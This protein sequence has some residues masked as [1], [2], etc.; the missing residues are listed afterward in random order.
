MTTTCGFVGLSE[1]NLGEAEWRAVREALERPTEIAYGARVTEFERTVAGLLGRRC[2]VAVSSGTAALHLALLAA[3]VGRGEEVLMPTLTFVAPA[4]AVRYVDAHPVLF[5]AEPEY[6][7]LDV[8]RLA[9]WV[10]ENCRAAD[11]EVRNLRSGRRVAAL[12]AVDLLGHPCDLDGLGEIAARLGLPLIDDAAESL[13]ATL[14]ARPAGAAADF[15][16]L[17]F[18]V[19]KV[20]TS[21]GGGMVLCDSEDLARHIRH[22]A[23]QAKVEGPGYMHDAIGFNYRMASV[24]AA[25][26][27]V[28]VGRL[29][30]FLGAKRSIAAHY[31]R[32]LTGVPGVRLTREAPWA[33]ST[34]WL[35]GIEIESRDFGMSAAELAERLTLR[36]IVSRPIFTP[37]HQ[38]GV[39]A[40]CQAQPCPVAE[41][42]GEQCL[43]LPSSTSIGMTELKRVTDAIRE[44]AG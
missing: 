38:R 21:G 19:N 8:E 27:T 29:D 11:G 1:P 10:K 32:E 35:Y 20:V 6:R 14:R 42:L 31:A 30:E 5:D 40:D 3:K 37:L 36:R 4:N 24:Q 34:H 2:A 39:H 33:S 44:F 16:C 28:Q 26:G 15:V 17:S 23:T 22:L 43:L 25:L 41:R 12:L 7:Q 9:G 18:N 13:G